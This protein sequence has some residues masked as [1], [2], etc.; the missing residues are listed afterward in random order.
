MDVQ[1][2]SLQIV[3]AVRSL[4]RVRT[5]VG[6]WQPSVEVF[7]NRILI[8]LTFVSF[9]ITPYHVLHVRTAIAVHSMY[10]VDS[11]TIPAGGTGTRY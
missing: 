8:E 2:E 7:N 9:A 5:T 6:V 3:S 10:P 4:A 1:R 11:Y